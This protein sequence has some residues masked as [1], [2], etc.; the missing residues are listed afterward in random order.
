MVPLVHEAAVEHPEGV[1][2]EAEHDAEVRDEEAGDQTVDDVAHDRAVGPDDVR[3]TE[4]VVDQADQGGGHQEDEDADPEVLPDPALDL[5][6]V[7]GSSENEA[8]QDVDDED[9]EVGRHGDS[10]GTRLY[11][12]VIILNG[13]C[14][15]REE[16]HRLRRLFHRF[17][18][19]R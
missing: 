10:R 12:Y 14:Q 18:R 15:S 13:F 1:G 11:V 8:G 3:D 5:L 16:N 9:D 19:H 7:E 17:H 6:D 2:E 4:E